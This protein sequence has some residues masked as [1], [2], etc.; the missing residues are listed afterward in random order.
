[1]RSRGPSDSQ[2]RQREAEGRAAALHNLGWEQ[3]AGGSIWARVITDA[4]ALFDDARA[5]F[6]DDTANVVTWERLHG[7]ALVMLVAIDQ[8][9]AFERRVRK[10]TG[11][12]ELARARAAFDVVGPNAS[13]LR[14]VAVHLDQYA[15]NQGHRQTGKRDPAMTE[16]YPSTF[17]YFPGEHEFVDDSCS[18]YLEIGGEMLPLTSAAR[19]AVAL[20]EVTERVREKYL[21]IAQRAA[22]AARS[23]GSPGDA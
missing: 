21:R 9:L 23:P 19:A 11:D 16:R 13:A 6:D 8:V 12:A 5:R 22:T 7:T 15:V 2:A 3:G 4:L 14:D 10:L 18:A 17:I 20:A 1:V